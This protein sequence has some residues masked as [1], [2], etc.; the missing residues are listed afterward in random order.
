PDAAGDTGGAPAL[1]DADAIT[2]A[3]RTR[4]VGLMVAVVVLA[5]L[6]PVAGW[7]GFLAAMAV[8]PAA[9]P[10]PTPTP[11]L[12]AGLGDAVVDQSRERTLTVNEWDSAISLLSADERAVVWWGEV[13]DQT[14]IVVDLL[15]DGPL[16]SCS[17]TSA[18]RSTGI[19][20]DASL[21]RIDD[22]DEREVQSNGPSVA[23]L[24]YP[25]DGQL[26]LRIDG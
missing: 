19:R 26:V 11:M 7:A 24:A 14:C 3:R 2:P 1:P 9:V 23:L 10:R 8:Q 22:E 6:L 18:V 15:P 25:Y 4:P 12:A 20:L 16:G 21:I 13:G 17:D 5:I